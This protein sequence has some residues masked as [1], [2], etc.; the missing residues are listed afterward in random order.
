MMDSNFWAFQAKDWI[1]IL[2]LG[3]TAFAVYIGPIRAVKVARREEVEAL[4]LR[5]K[6]EIFASLMK[7]RRFQLDPEHVSSLNLIQVY[8]SEEE[9][10]LA[11]YKAYIRLLSR[12]LIPGVAD[13][14]FWK[15]RDDAFID[16]VY[17][18]A[19]ATG[20]S[21]DKKEIE[22]L[23]YSPSGWASDQETIRRL[24]GLLIE[25][26]ENKRPIP[27]TN[28]INPTVFNPFP[29]APAIDPN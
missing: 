6:A 28:F 27:V 16:L 14:S 23:A 11:A 22:E 8:F 13:E 21:Q 17:A 19:R 24:H 20:F 15:E 3:V 2:I 29:P 10:V 26:F 25:I 9:T 7:T 5:Q 12:K 4:K 18:I 1:N